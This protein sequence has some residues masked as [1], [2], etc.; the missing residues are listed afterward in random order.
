MRR[1]HPLGGISIES[2]PDETSKDASSVGLIENHTHWEIG[3]MPAVYVC[4]FVNE[5]MC[6]MVAPGILV[7]KVHEQN[8]LEDW[9]T[10]T[11]AN[12]LLYFQDLASRTNI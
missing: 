3:V 8:I 6:S 1:I 5:T 11:R 2:S 4:F 12:D 9:Q 10:A 7:E